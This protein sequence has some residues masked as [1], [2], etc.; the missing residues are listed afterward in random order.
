LYA[1][2]KTLRKAGQTHGL[3]L[4]DPSLVAGCSV[5][6]PADSNSAACFLVPRVGSVLVGL[7]SADSIQAAVAHHQDYSAA[8]TAHRQDVPVCF[9]PVSSVDS[10]VPMVHRDAK[11]CFLQVLSAGLILVCPAYPD[12][13]VCPAYRGCLVCQVCLGCRVS[14]VYL[15]CSVYP[16]CL[17]C[18][19]CWVCLDCPVSP[20]HRVS[21]AC[22]GCRVSPV[23]LVCSVYPD[24]LVCRVYLDCRVFPAYWVSQAV[25]GG[26]REAFPDGRV[27]SADPV[28][29][30]V[31]DDSPNCLDIPDD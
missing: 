17:V 19:E 25:D 18:P 27:S 7:V 29:G 8:P 23:Y 1:C 12:C 11:A 22:P 4:A 31:V 28:A 30:S 2:R 13:L 5:S 3:A 20:V 16:D 14:P 26:H 6:V 10:A 24:C 21:P 15:V 9:R